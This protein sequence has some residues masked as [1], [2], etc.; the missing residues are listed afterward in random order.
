MGGLKRALELMGVV[1][2]GVIA[3]DN[4]P[5]SKKITRM[6]CRHAIT[7]DDVALVSE[8]MVREWRR[9]F[10]RVT[11]VLLAG[12][13]PCIHH[14][15]LNVNRQGAEG[16]TSQ[17]LD[18]MLKVR[19]WLKVNAGAHNLPP[20]TVA[21]MYE[22]VVMDDADLETQSSKIGWYPMYLQK[23]LTLGIVGVHDCTGS[24]T[25]TW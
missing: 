6:H 10:P 11:K 20:W 25:S 24:G 9:Q 1:P 12:G 15:S 3:V 17:L 14:S 16:S 13:W 23:P 2:Q 21:E 19:E 5:T 18:A 22:N 7:I 8:E 4:H